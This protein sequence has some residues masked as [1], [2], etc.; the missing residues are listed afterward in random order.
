[1]KAIKIKF[2]KSDDELFGQS[3]W[4]GA[5][6]LPDDW[7]YPEMPDGDDT[8]LTFICQINCAELAPYDPD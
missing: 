6:D 4:W 5:P 7:E 1:M 2:S 3:K 8:P